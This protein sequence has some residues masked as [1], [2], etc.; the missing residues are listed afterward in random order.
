[1]A[2]ERTTGIVVLIDSDDVGAAREAYEAKLDSSFFRVRLDRA[3][4]LQTAYMRAMAELGS[5]PQK[6]AD[7]AARMGRESSQV[8]PIRSQLI[9]MGLLYTPQHGYAAFTVPDF[10]TFMLRAVPELDVPEIHRRRRRR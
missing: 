9:D 1:M 3:T 4:P 8:A 6:A 5:E 10:D 7:V 2:K